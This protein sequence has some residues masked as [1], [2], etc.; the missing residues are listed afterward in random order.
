MHI[1]IYFELFLID[2]NALNNT[3][4]LIYN[5]RLFVSYSIYPNPIDRNKFCFN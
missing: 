3:V 1:S 2:C 4:G 5:F